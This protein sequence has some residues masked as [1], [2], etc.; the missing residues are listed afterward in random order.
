MPCDLDAFNDETFGPAAA[1]SKL[2]SFLQNPGTTVLDEL[3]GLNISHPASAHED[4]DYN[5]DTFGEHENYTGQEKLPDFFMTND[6]SADFNSSASQPPLPA[7]AVILHDHMPAHPPPA[8]PTP[9]MRL[10]PPEPLR[11]VMQCPP[12]L[13]PPPQSLASL[14]TPGMGATWHAGYVPRGMH[15]PPRQHHPPPFPPHQQHQYP[16]GSGGRGGQG[17]RGGEGGRNRQYPPNQH[18]QQ[19]RGPPTQSRQ[20][21]PAPRPDLSQGGPV[22]PG[23]SSAPT[24]WSPPPA[25][26]HHHHQQAMGRPPAPRP[27][28]AGLPHGEMMTPPDVR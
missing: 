9:P 23:L 10:Y 28:A 18:H 19:H 12:G 26:H 14:S 15:P 20:T 2:P 11:Q 21:P 8:P 7:G 27:F 25:H 16:A 24:H 5:D 1:S 17:G 3:A 22:A 4:D 6:S 13:V